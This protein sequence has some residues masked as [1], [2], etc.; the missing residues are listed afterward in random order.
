MKYLDR[1]ERLLDDFIEIAERNKDEDVLL[2]LLD[3]EHGKVLNV[4][5]AIKNIGRKDLLTS[6]MFSENE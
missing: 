3:E 5:M 6:L 1:D 4:I 2:E